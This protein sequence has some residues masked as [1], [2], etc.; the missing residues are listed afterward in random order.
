MLPS[1]VKLLLVFLIVLANG[2]FVAAE[3]ALVS[4]RRARIE[5]LASGGTPGAKAVLRALNHLDAL[6]SSTQFGVTLAS[7]ALGW[8]GESTLEHLVEPVFE[9]Y[10]P[11]NLVAAAAHTASV[12]VAFGVITYFHIVLGEFAPK[13]LAIEHAE[14]IALV[15][16]PPMAIFY[17]VFKPFIWVINRSGISL[18]KMFGMQ[19]RL[20]H[21]AAYSEEEIRHLINQSHQSGHL[22]LE[23][24]T[25][26]HNVFEFAELTAREIMIPRTEVTAI[27]EDS[28]F[29]EVVRLFQSS[30]YSRLPIYQ[31]HFDNITG[32]L[33]NKDVMPYLL[34]PESFTLK[35]ATHQPVFIP[36][37]AKLSD[38][39]AQLQKV[40]VHM[41][42]VVDEHGGVEGILTLEDILEEIVGEIQDEHDEALVDRTRERGG[43]VYS[44]EGSMSVRELNRKF[45][46]SLPESEDYNTIA[47]FMI[48]RAG[49]L[50]LPND[51]VQW[52]GTKFTVERVARRRIT[53][54]RMEQA[55]EQ[56]TAE[57]EQPAVRG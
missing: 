18:L 8:V 50:L 41:G 52:N 19:A 42:I 33:H 28:S 48:S 53:R 29:E 15:V 14:K 55:P 31:D 20:G 45:D 37:T 54:I 34:K 16:A 9:H 1:S 3:F 44:I 24:K 32:I 38:V 39:L 30:G 12:V 57:A 46:L 2:F 43:G 17:R 13:A 23:E 11:V 27:E 36:D 7:L 22:E 25:L 26:I 10:L 56:Q 47:G 40:R 51:T 4:V 5:M 6:L 35:A 21:H 49:R